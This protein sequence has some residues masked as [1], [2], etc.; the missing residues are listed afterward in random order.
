MLGPARY[1]NIMLEPG[2]SAKPASVVAYPTTA[3]HLL[4]GL[5]GGDVS[6]TPREPCL[7]GSLQPLRVSRPFDAL[8]LLMRDLIVETEAGEWGETAL[9]SQQ[10]YMLMGKN[11]CWSC[12]SVRFQEQD[13]YLFSVQAYSK[14]EDETDELPTVQAHDA[15]AEDMDDK[16]TLPHLHGLRVRRSPSDKGWIRLVPAYANTT[17]VSAGWTGETWGETIEHLVG[18][19]LEADLPTRGSGNRRGVTA[20]TKRKA[21][22]FRNIKKEHPGYS[23][24]R[25]AREATYRARVRVSPGETPPIT[26][27]TM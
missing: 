6:G 2:G 3:R 14:P 10:T 8:V 19:V 24:A 16:W 7:D 15:C 20:E 11:G 4:F 21:E 9:G 22:L 23:R 18:A 25:V 1:G 17:E 12:G 27:S 5:I 26:K 13:A